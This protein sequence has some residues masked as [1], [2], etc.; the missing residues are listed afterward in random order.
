MLH[1]FLVPLFEEI[2]E[3]YV[4]KE[5]VMF[6]F[7]NVQPVATRVARYRKKFPRSAR[8]TSRRQFRY[9]LAIVTFSERFLLL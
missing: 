1:D 8:T 2:S 3:A 4:T 6:P 9:A 7:G 5:I